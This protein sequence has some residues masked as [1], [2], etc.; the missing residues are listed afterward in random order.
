RVAIREQAHEV[1]ER[2]L[3]QV[4]ARRLER[5]Q[6][7]R[8]KTQRDAVLLPGFLA[9]TGHETN[10]ARIGERLAVE[11]RQQHG[12]GF[13]IADVFAA[14]NVSVA[15]AMLQ[16]NAPLPA[17]GARRRSGVWRELSADRARH[18]HR[19]VARQPMTPIHVARFER[20]LDEQP[21]K[22]GAVDEEIALDTLAAL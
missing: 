19:A 14:V 17:R 8:G 1:G 18:G 15:D 20:L 21:A 12:G 7:S 3:N 10:R 22:A 13:V 11:V 6:E 9:P 16:R 5:L 2:A 4:D